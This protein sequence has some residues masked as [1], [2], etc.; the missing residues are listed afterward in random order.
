M[1]NFDGFL[2]EK[3]CF[4]IVAAVEVQTVGCQE[5]SSLLQLEAFDGENFQGRH[6][7]ADVGYTHTH[8]LVLSLSMK[9]SHFFYCT[10]NM[11]MFSNA[12]LFSLQSAYI[13]QCILFSM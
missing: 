12:F 4:K 5:S 6:T 3:R 13:L 8:T 2:L 1:R 7:G 10:Y 9:L 11:L